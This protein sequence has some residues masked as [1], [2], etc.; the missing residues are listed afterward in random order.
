[1]SVSALVWSFDQILYCNESDDDG[2]SNS[3]PSLVWLARCKLDHR[4]HRHDSNNAPQKEKNTSGLNR[5]LEFPKSLDRVIV[6]SYLFLL[7]SARV[8]KV[9]T[10][11]TPFNASRYHGP[12]ILV[13]D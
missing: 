11:Q 10:S 13:A 7:S 8:S 2:S 5:R 12:S 9:P 1:M 6:P 3:K 4:V